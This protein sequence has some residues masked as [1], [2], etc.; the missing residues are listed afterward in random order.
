[1]IG[2]C[3]AK[4]CFDTNCETS[5]VFMRCLVTCLQTSSSCRVAVL[6]PQCLRKTSIFSSLCCNDCFMLY[7]LRVI[8]PTFYTFKCV[9]RLK[10]TPSVFPQE[11]LILGPIINVWC[12]K[13]VA[14]IHGFES[15]CFKW[16]VPNHWT[17]PLSLFIILRKWFILGFL[18]DMWLFTASHL[19]HN[20][21]N[22]WFTTNTPFTSLKKM[23][24]SN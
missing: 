1:M 19:I 7:E 24:H 23:I 4:L 9:V 20:P 5:V 15:R 22:Q 18:I 2:G 11:Y 3:F 21:E 6:H 8:S 12:L 10:L 17:L 13:T 16:E 14:S